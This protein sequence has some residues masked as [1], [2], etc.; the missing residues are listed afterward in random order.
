MFMLLGTVELKNGMQMRAKYNYGV[1]KK[2]E[3]Y[4]I[5]DHDEHTVQLNASNYRYDKNEIET[6]F[7]IASVRSLS[8]EL[9][10]DILEMFENLLDEHGIVIPDADRTGDEEEA[11]LYGTTYFNLESQIS[12]LLAEYVD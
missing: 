7:E 2:D 12:N 4:T 6:N 10:T 3:C 8:E 9:A 5:I 1:V 11:C